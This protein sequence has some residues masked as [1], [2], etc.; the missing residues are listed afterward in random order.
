MALD[1]LPLRARQLL[2]NHEYESS[3]ATLEMTEIGVEGVGSGWKVKLCVISVLPFRDAGVRNN[4]TN[5]RSVMGK[6]NGSYSIE[7]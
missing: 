4:A 6:Q 1:L 3:E 5:W 7:P 2:V